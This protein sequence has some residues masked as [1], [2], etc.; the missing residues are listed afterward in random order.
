MKYLKV[1]TDLRDHL[2]PFG[3]AEKGRL[4]DAMMEYAECGIAPELHGNERYIWETVRAEI[5][6]QRAAYE[7]QC[8]VNKDNIT[9][10]YETLRNATNGYEPKQEHKTKDY[11]T[12]EKEKEKRKIFTPPTAADVAAYCAERNNGID[13]DAFVNFYASKG[14]M[15]GKNR[16]KDWKAAVRT[17]EQKHK[18]E[19]V[20]Q[21]YAAQAD[22]NNW[23]AWVRGD[24]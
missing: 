11:K 14:W 18:Q 19:H 21:L 20:E 10:R 13:A 5:D 23:A 3:D 12:K 1:W 7:R 24:I 4:F 2:K 6:R 16:M 8:A 22:K 9:K 17:W 15:I